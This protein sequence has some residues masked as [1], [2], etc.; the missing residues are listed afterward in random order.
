MLIL[1]YL[2]WTFKLLSTQ[3]RKRV[4][5]PGKSIAINEYM[6]WFT[7][8]LS[9]TLHIPEKPIFVRFKIWALV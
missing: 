8:R 2:A 6:A 9:D 7:G 1:Y 5:Y 4:W 3:N